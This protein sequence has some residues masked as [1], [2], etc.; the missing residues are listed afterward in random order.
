MKSSFYTVGKPLLWTVFLLALIIT[1]ITAAEASPETTISVEPYTNI[2]QVGES[3]TIN[4]TLTNV[5]NLYGVDVRLRWN[6]SILQVVDVDV[7]LGVE[8]HPDG[9]LHEDILMAMNEIRNDLGR[10]W[11]A[12][13][14]Y[15][16]TGGIPPPSFNGSGNIVRL[17]FNVTNIGSCELSL[18]TE[19][20]GKPPPEGEAP[21]IDHAA[22]NGFFGRQIRIS[23]SPK[24]VT[25]G[26]NVNISGFIIPAQADV[27]VTILYRRE[28]ETDWGNLTTV[29]TNE[30]GNY[31]YI[32]QPQE[33]GEY[34]IRATAIIEGS[35]EISSSVFVTVEAPE[36]EQPTWIYIVIIIV[37]AI[38]VIATV[39]AYRKKSKS[40]IKTGRK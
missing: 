12:A 2:A 4:I 8:S 36:P 13:T 32:W 27:E 15:N 37:I 5:Q 14:S 24:N 39:L 21:L 16:S 18:E 22:I 25:I 10:Y 11:L 1:Q 26:E 7:R 6:A 30:L 34:E 29:D 9:V 17:T 23:A 3:F 31:Q 20:R 40:S 33:E 19:M 28:G 38:V 35:E